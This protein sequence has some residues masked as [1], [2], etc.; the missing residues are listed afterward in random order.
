MPKKPTRDHIIETA[1]RLFYERGY[2][3]TSFADIAGIINI[4][5]GNF[6]HHFKTKDEILNAVIDQRLANTQEMLESWDQSADAPI[7]RIRCFVNILVKNRAKIISFGC[8]VG[9]L[10]N[11]LSK[12]NHS[13]LVDA[14]E[15]FLLFRIWLK[16]H[17]RAAGCGKD[18]DDNAMH[19]LALSQGAATIASAF[20]D[21]QF[22]NSEVQ[23]INA[24]IDSVVEPITPS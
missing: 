17:F 2:E 15:V 1:D 24:W 12:L 7:S 14:K 6:Y 9:T 10:T 11:E 16:N 21:E 4:S 5:R 22:I 13:A 20:K 8:P 18:S 23:R 19:L 3:G